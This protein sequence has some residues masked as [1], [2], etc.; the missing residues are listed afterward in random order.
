LAY[1]TRTKTPVPPSNAPYPEL[2]ANE[3]ALAEVTSRGETA[4]LT[5]SRLV[6]AGRDGE[7]STALAHIASLRVRFERLPRA[8]V[9]GL[10]LACIAALL[11]AVSGPTRAFLL[12]QGASI[13]ASARQDAAKVAEGEGGVAPALAR[14]AHALARAAQVIPWV[15]AL[16]LALG[17][18]NLARGVLGRTVV[19]VHAGGGEL[20]LVRLGRSRPI[21]AF[22]K[23]V[24]RHLPAPAP[25]R[26]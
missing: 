21:E 4:V 1:T 26:R 18:V 20:E 16:L 23:E 6:I 13:E 14:G 17:L 12:A 24:G 22:V 11:F 5:Q 10:V 3:R 19:T 9:S 7:S 2:D 8:I 25:T 15:G